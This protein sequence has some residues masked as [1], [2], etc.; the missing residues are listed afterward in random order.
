MPA[1]HPAVTAVAAEA[2]AVA[3]MVGVRTAARAGWTFWLRRDALGVVLVGVAERFVANS[4]QVCWR[5]RMVRLL[6]RGRPP[7]SKALGMPPGGMA[8][9]W[10]WVPSGGSD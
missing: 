5:W 3:G 10:G 6:C 2:M 8:L 4:S 9:G 1:G 7:L